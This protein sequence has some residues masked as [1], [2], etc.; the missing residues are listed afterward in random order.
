MLLPRL[1][2]DSDVTPE[3]HVDSRH[4]YHRAVSKIFP[5]QKR[6]EDLEDDVEKALMTQR[7]EKKCLTDGK[8]GYLGQELLED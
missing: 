3:T 2:L 6:L 8:P 7:D 5:C 1:P 4:S